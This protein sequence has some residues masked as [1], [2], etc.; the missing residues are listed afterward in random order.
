MQQS[1]RRQPAS[2]EVDDI[3]AQVPNHKAG[4]H[5]VYDK[6]PDAYDALMTRHDCAAIEELLLGHAKTLLQSRTSSPQAERAPGLVIGDFGC[7]TGRLALMLAPVARM[8][9]LS[10]A[11]KPM[12]QKCAARFA[13]APESS[14]G[15]RWKPTFAPVLEERTTTTTSSS[16]LEEE[17]ASPSGKSLEPSVGTVQLYVSRFEDFAIDPIDSD[18]STECRCAECAAA[19]N[20]E[21]SAVVLQPRGWSV[22]PGSPPLDFVTCGWSLSFVM[23]ALWGTTRWHCN[24]LRAVA[25]M[26]GALDPILGGTIC[27]VETLGNWSDTPVRKSSLHTYMTDVLGFTM[28]WRRTD[29]K[30]RS[31][32]E[33]QRCVTFFYGGKAAERLAMTDDPQTLLECTGVWTRHFPPSPQREEQR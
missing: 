11:A 15:I 14:Q 30:F 25:A 5:V 32:E 2:A 9:V 13:V 6:Y 27:I 24:I 18:R 21:A 16:A 8:L 19:G 28:E 22:L 31:K 20:F 3:M 12:L 23:T 29:Y 1:K 17:A 4:R 26:V 7:G 10:D 33:A